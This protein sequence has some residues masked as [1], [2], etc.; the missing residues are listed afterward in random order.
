MAQTGRSP[1]VALRRS[2]SGHILVDGETSDGE[3]G[4]FIVDTAAARSVLSRTGNLFAK[5]VAAP[6]TTVQAH[7]AGGSAGASEIARLPFFRIG[8]TTIA[9]AEF[10][11]LDLEP[12]AAKLGCAVDGILGL[13]TLLRDGFWLDLRGNRLSL[14]FAEAPPEP[15]ESA[16]RFE[17]VP[18]QVTSDHLIAIRATAGDRPFLAVLDTGAAN[19]LVNPACL[20]ALLGT[21]RYADTRRDDLRALG[22][23][24]ASI[25]V[26]EASCPS[27]RIGD[28]QMPPQPILVAQLPVFQRF[29]APGEGIMLLGL[30]TLKE[31]TFGIDTDASI[32]WL[33]QA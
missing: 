27:F 17:P 14:S 26:R 22:A 11:A 7:G 1:T 10:V 30:D 21:P 8:G 32:L 20:E 5:A 25:P 4:R 19:S 18:L 29:A 23:D 33:S 13:D 31:R 16:P 9:P 6:E 12:V 28:A 3:S 15:P 2:G 24:G